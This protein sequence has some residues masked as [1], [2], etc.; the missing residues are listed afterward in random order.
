MDE[1]LKILFSWNFIVFCLGLAGI[2]FVLRTLIE[3]FILN[4]PKLPGNKNSPIW[5]SLILPIAPVVFG[6]LAG[7]FAQ[8][9]PYPEGLSASQYGRVS[10]GL[11]AG[12]LSG[13]IYRVIAEF[14]RSKM[15][16]GYTAGVA[17]TSMDMTVVQE[18][19]VTKITQVSTPSEQVKEIPTTIEKSDT[20]DN[21]S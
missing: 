13:L 10:F 5:G 17:G 6:A 15:A 2:T 12:L 21:V 18:G 19:D 9:Y 1:L 14:L 7:Y 20:P 8:N 4:N 3:Y 16:K 11:V